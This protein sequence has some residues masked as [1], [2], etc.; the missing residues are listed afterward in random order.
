MDNSW[1]SLV[2]QLLQSPPAMWEAWVWSLGW[3]DPLEECMTIQSSNLSWRIPRDRGACRGYKE[4]DTTEHKIPRFREWCGLLLP[5]PRRDLVLL[6]TFLALLYFNIPVVKVF[7]LQKSANTGNQPLSFCRKLVV[8]HLLTHCQL[9]PLL[10][11]KNETSE[12]IN[13]LNRLKVIVMNQLHDIN[14]KFLW[15]IFF[16][17]Q[18]KESLFFF[19]QFCKFL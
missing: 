3:E 17:K 6:I 5:L 4:S 19:L 8:K 1:A 13:L 16:K 12:K 2:A 10:E 11:I 7:M 9:Y 18:W 15:K 14:R